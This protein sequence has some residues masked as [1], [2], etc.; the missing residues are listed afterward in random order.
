MNNLIVRP[1][2]SWTSQCN[3][4]RLKVGHF[5][6]NNQWA[7]WLILPHIMTPNF[8]F[9]CMSSIYFSLSVYLFIPTRLLI[10]TVITIGLYYSCKLNFSIFNSL[11]IKLHSID[12]IL[13]FLAQTGLD[14]KKL[15]AVHG[16]VK[17][18]TANLEINSYTFFCSLLNIFFLWKQS[19]LLNTS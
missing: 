4:S 18:K 13:Q 19:N 6:P 12:H 10:V 1:I 15:L 14:F 9:I 2:F 7:L 17:E 16:M 3:F 8:H 5:H 11:T